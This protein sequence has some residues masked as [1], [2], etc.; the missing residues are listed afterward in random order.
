MRQ[1]KSRFAR[2]AAAIGLTAVMSFGLA[3]C[4]SDGGSGG[5]SGAGAAASGEGSGSLEG[6]G[7]TIVMFM[8]STA[9]IYQSD[10][11]ASVKA[12]AEE[13]GFEVKIFENK[14]D[15]TEQDQQV[16]QFIATGEVPAAFIWWPS[17]SQAGI[18]SS[19]LLSQIA[20]VFQVNQ[21]VLPE[22]EEYIT[23][24]AGVRAYGI[25]ETAGD[26]LEAARE[27]A[28]AAGKQ[29]HSEEGNLIEITFPAGYQSGIDRHDGMLAS[30]EDAPFNLLAS[31]P[32][33]AGFD[34]Q[35]AFDIA[36]Q[37]IPKFSSEGIDFVFAQNLSMA[38]GVVTALEQNGLTPGEDVWVIAG[39]DAGDKTPLLNG[40]V[41]SAVI[42]SP[43]VEGKLIIQ[44][45][46]KYLASGEVTDDVVNLEL[47]ATE[48]ELTADAP[49]KTTY[50]PNPP[51]R[52][53]DIEGFEFWGLSY[54]ELGSQ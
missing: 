1:S 44:T 32:T 25:G 11:A 46:A 35:G 42:Q 17:N 27:E 37:V 51:I 39:N 15:Q 28:L 34:S 36:S 14:T 54:E 48:P 4:S 16:Q 12:E 13:L 21:S 50:M 33:A 31:E 23:A 19:R 7:Q 20:P 22:G 49:A 41:Y 45:V 5:G 10:E 6:G 30:T 8:P 18:N 3:A 24:Y 52:L 38:A 40:Q 2:V 53:A 47:E 43:V 26:M 9:T 29:L